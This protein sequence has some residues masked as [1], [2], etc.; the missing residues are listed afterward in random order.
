MKA[1]M[2][3]VRVVGAS[4]SIGRLA[5]AQA[6]ETGLETRALA[7]DVVTAIGVTKHTAGRCS[8]N[9]APIAQASSTPPSTG[10]TCHSATSRHLSS[11]DS[12]P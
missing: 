10:T 6:L 4:G 7:R 3:T 5:A 12:T 2:T 8:P 1:G 11:P 9:C